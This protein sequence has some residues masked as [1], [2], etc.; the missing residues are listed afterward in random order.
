MLSRAGQQRRPVLFCLRLFLG[1]ATL[2]L[3]VRR[4]DPAEATLRA[5]PHLLA[6]VILATIFLISSQAVAAFRWKLI[7]ADDLLPWSYLLRL[8]II[9]E[10]F[11]L[12]LPTSV[13]GDAVR[14]VAAARSSERPDGAI[15]TVLIDRGF[16]VLATIAYAL[17]G[18][19][20]APQSLANLSRSGIGWHA[21][22]TTGTILVLGFIGLALLGLSRIGRVRAFWNEGMAA[23]KRLLRAPVRLMSVAA[24]SGLSQGLI[25]LLWLTLAAGMNFGIPAT[26]FLWAVPIVSLSALLPLTLAGLGLREVVWLVL[27][28]GTGIAPADIV[29]FSLLYLACNI[30]VGILGAFLF[31]SLGL[32]VE[33]AHRA[34]A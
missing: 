2:G 33:S 6:A 12:F 23:S 8:Y 21:P 3:I 1:L 16:G 31:V 14:A 17:L 19:A 24:L 27:L 15:A 13:G 30:L 28:A 10:F 11:G 29:G 18:L 20:V 25:I 22:G 5:T 4:V 9:G 32:T 34:R 7:L 26:T